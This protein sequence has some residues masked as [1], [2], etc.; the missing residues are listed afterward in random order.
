M[1]TFSKLIFARTVWTF[2]ISGAVKNGSKQYSISSNARIIEHNF[3]GR[4]L[5]WFAKFLVYLTIKALRIV[6]VIETEL[7]RFTGVAIASIPL[8]ILYIDSCSLL[9]RRRTLR[10]LFI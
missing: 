10:L 8:K 2:Y 1:E 4:Q 6:A 5:E 3:K 9:F 7:L